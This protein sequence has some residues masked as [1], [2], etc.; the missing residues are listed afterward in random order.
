MVYIFED[1]KEVRKAE[2]NE[3]Y[4]SDLSG[5]FEQ[6]IGTFSSFRNH[7]IYTRRVCKENPMGPIL[8]FYKEWKKWIEEL[9]DKSSPAKAIKEAVEIYE[10]K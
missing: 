2:N 3:W 10:G 5:S 7:P 6:W 9:E 1:K 4:Y 8:K